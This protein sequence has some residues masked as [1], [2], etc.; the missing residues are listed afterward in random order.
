VKHRVKCFVHNTGK[1]DFVS[2][3]KH[4]CKEENSVGIFWFV[5]SEEQLPRLWNIAGRPWSA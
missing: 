5:K 3:G 4:A 2:G 1:C